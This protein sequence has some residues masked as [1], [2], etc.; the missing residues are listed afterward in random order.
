MANCQ[1]KLKG[2]FFHPFPSFLNFPK[3]IY[4]PA[5]QEIFFYLKVHEINHGLSFIVMNEKEVSLLLLQVLHH[6]W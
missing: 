5:F 1:N 2:G 6:H 4:T 3:L